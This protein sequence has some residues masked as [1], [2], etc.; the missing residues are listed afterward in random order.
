LNPILLLACWLFRL[1]YTSSKTF[2]PDYTA[3]H[4]EPIGI[5]VT[6]QFR[7]T[8]VLLSNLGREIGYLLGVFVVFL[9]LSGQMKR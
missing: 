4:T 3:L 2:L 9:R 7:I 6:L 8:E 5:A 1:I